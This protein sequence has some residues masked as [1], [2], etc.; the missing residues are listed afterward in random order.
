M[1]TLRILV[2]IPLMI[3]DA[4]WSVITRDDEEAFIE[5]QRQRFIRMAEGD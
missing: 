5:D 2:S 3:A 1:E 4:L